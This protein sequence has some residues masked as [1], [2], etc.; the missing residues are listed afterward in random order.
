M[1]FIDEG[2][3]FKVEW[4]VILNELLE[5]NGQLLL[6]ADATQDLYSRSKN[7]VAEQIKGLNFKGGWKKLTCSY[8][9][10]SNVAFISKVFAQKFI[11]N[12]NL[13]AIQL[14][15]LPE[16]EQ[17]IEMDLFDQPIK[18]YQCNLPEYKD[19]DN[20][21][22]HE[23][24]IIEKIKEEINLLLNEFSKKYGMRSYKDICILCSNKA[25]GRRL[26]SELANDNIPTEAVYSEN[27]SVNRDEKMNLGS[28]PFYLKCS[29]IH[30]YKGWESKAIILVNVR[31][32]IYDTKDKPGF[33][34]IK[35][36]FEPLTDEAHS[37]FYVGLTRVSYTPEGCKLIIF[38]EMPEY[39]SFANDLSEKKKY[40]QFENLD[41]FAMQDK[42][43]DII[44]YDEVC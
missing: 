37:A 21:N 28:H 40:I 23:I 43:A 6:M 36:D 32:R 25:F 42:L 39:E 24:I 17:Q 7:L 10:P 8:R 18:W 33:Y 22:N 44:L 20:L 16:P 35:I 13:S 34:P 9:L 30:S 4:L 5:E 3:D 1:Y 15:I 41:E 19:Q 31:K 26:I 12:P 14:C 29:T 2:Q 27:D 11:I 38:N